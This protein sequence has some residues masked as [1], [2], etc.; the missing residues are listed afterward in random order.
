MEEYYEISIAKHHTREQ[1]Q[2]NN[3]LVEG[4]KIQAEAN[5]WGFD[6]KDFDDKKI[7]DRI[8]NFLRCKFRFRRRGED[9]RTSEER[10]DDVRSVFV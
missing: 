2:F 4:I 3:Q 7:R 5:G 1:Q 10:C 8:T 6:P 9:E